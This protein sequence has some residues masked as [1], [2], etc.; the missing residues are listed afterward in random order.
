M[1]I[2]GIAVSGF[3]LIYAAGLDT[4]STMVNTMALVMPVLLGILIAT[5]SITSGTILHQ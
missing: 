2:I 4:V 5:G 3:R 1:V